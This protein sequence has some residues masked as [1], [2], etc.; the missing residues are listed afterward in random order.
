M[1]LVYTNSSLNLSAASSSNS[2]Q[3]L[4][5]SRNPAAL[6]PPRLK[7]P[8][9][10]LTTRHHR[11]VDEGTRHKEVLHSPLNSRGWVIQE[12]FLS[13][14]VVHFGASQIAWECFENAATEIRPT[15]RVNDFLESLKHRVFE[16]LIF[17]QVRDPEVTRRLFRFLWVEIVKDYSSRK[18]TFPKDKLVAIAG[19]AKFFG[20]I[21]GDKYVAGLWMK[22]IVLQLLWKASDHTE[23]HVIS[24][25]QAPTRSWASLDTKV[26]F[27]AIDHDPDGP[28]ARIMSPDVSTVDAQ[29]FGPVLEARL[30]L[31]GWVANLALGLKTPRNR[32]YYIAPTDQEGK[33]AWV[34]E[35]CP[36]GHE[37]VAIFDSSCAWKSLACITVSYIKPSLSLPG[38]LKGLVL[39]PIDEGVSA[40]DTDTYRRVGLLECKNSSSLKA[41]F[42]PSNSGE[43]HGDAAPVRDGDQEG[44]WQMRTITIV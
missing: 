42:H 6:I 5:R 15:N 9:R 10:W 23:S 24:P 19:I 7:E 36:E 27:T 11:L 35:K 25:Y 12:Q 40:T 37:P 1:N 38:H 44:P 39:A 3:G 17:R 21:T 14:R 33:T 2:H 20:G 43:G 31:E 16:A 30:V 8:Q 18:F 34:R 29:E 13:P 28:G 22:D 26:L 4:Y 32:R 41:F